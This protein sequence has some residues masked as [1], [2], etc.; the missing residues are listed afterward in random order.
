MTTSNRNDVV[1]KVNKNDVTDGN[2][3]Q[4]TVLGYALASTN[5]REIRPR[6]STYRNVV[7]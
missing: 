7:F 3:R 5:L 1:N 6:V 2:D 4:T